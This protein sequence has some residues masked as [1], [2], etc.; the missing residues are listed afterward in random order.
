[1]SETLSNSINVNLEDFGGQNLERAEKILAGISGGF[2]KALKNAMRRATTH[3]RSKSADAIREKYDISKK[4]I[5][6]EENVKIRYSYS[7]GQVI[8]NVH[9]SGL[10]IPLYRFGGTYPKEPKRNMSKITYIS[11]NATEGKLV[12]AHPS[13]AARAH[14]FKGTSPVTFQN[15]F[16]LEMKSGHRG[17]F[18][19]TGGIAST[20]NAEIKELMGSS[21]AQM[22]G[23]KEVAEKLV[24]SAK[25]KFDERL[26][27]E[28]TRLLAG[29]GG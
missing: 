2:D 29:I 16:V 22:L 27:H 12:P 6:A 1:M 21:V 4:D 18:E 11:N 8:A 10:K 15:A 7:P 24:T 5:R 9:F 19:R 25:E 28:I 14:Q 23:N 20:G 26:D 3:L 13:I 17:I